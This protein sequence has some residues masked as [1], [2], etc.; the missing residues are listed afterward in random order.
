[1]DVR[2]NPLGH[3]DAFDAIVL[4]A[5]AERMTIAAHLVT[6]EFFAVARL[7]LAERGGTLY[8]NLIVAPEPGRLDARI[9]RTLR[10]VFAWCAA[11]AVGDTARWHNRVYACRRS[12][13]DGDAVVY[14][15][16]ETRSAL[17]GWRR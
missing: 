1:M 15:D 8:V 5:F 10:S 7:G 14:T 4:D 6:Q 2:A 16:A 13:L 3:G 12:A 17:D 9:D 11:A